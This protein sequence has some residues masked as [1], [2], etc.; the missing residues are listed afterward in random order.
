MEKVVKLAR[1]ILIAM[2][3]AVLLSMIMTLV[4]LIIG[5]HLETAAAETMTCMVERGHYVNV[6]T[7]PTES[8]SS[9]GRKIHGGDEIEVISVSDG[10]ITID[11]R[12]VNAYVSAIYFEAPVDADYE[13]SANGRVRWRKAPGGAVGGYYQPGE[14]VHVDGYRY[15]DGATWARIGDRYVDMAYLVPYLTPDEV[16]YYAREDA[17]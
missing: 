12:G 7:G 16:A 17:R 15:G 8:A 11:W 2:L 5:L 3:V 14:I 10:W 6:R 13:V 9:N 4:T 1:A